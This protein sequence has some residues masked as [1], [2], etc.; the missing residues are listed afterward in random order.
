M[1]Y[2]RFEEAM[3]R[4]VVD[5]RAR[6]SQKPGYGIIVGYHKYSNKADVLLSRPGS[7]E[8]GEIIHSVPCPVNLGIQGTNPQ[9]GQAAWVE[10]KDGVQSNPVVTHLFS[11]TYEENDFDRHQRINSALPKYIGGL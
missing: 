1:N 10:F 4:K 5:R 9:V 3:K 11:G 6:E 7:D 2:P 8:P